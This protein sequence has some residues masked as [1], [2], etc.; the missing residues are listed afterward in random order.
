MIPGKLLAP[1]KMAVKLEK[2]PY[3]DIGPH[4]LKESLAHKLWDISV[5]EIKYLLIESLE[6][7]TW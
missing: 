4:L 3:E 5:E 1:Y 6:N 7:D 2:I